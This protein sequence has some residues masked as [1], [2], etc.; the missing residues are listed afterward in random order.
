MRLTMNLEE[1]GELQT[2]AIEDARIFNADFPE[3]ALVP[4]M[5]WESHAW[6]KTRHFVE[7]RIGHALPLKA[8]ALYYRLLELAV[9]ETRFRD[10]N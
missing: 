6:H 5:A 8:R 7:G 3:R 2:A 4:S 9:I 10:E 1:V